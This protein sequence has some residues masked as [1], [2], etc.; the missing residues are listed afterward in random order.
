MTPSAV[1]LAL[2]FTGRWLVQNSPA[3]RV[4]SHGTHL[5]GSTYAI[6]FVGVDERRSTADRH[7]WRRFLGTEPNERFVGF[8]RPILAPVDGEV[9]VVHDGEPDHVARRSL[10]VL[11]Y[12]WQQP[13]RARLGSAAVAGNHVGIALADG[14]TFVFLVHLRSRSVR[15][16]VGDVVRTGEVLG[17]CGNSGNSTQPH[18]HVQATDDLDIERSSGVPIAF[19]GF[20]EEPVRGRAVERERGVPA[21]GSVVEPR[22]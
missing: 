3:R 11:P 17:T 10:V 18:V 8:D 12:P 21:E 6:D 13:Q 22:G 19:R 20:R 15:V 9:V 14:G 4:P 1:L 16:A 2:P 7:D 5:F